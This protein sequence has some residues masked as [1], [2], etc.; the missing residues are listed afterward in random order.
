MAGKKLPSAHKSSKSN[1]VRVCSIPASAPTIEVQVACQGKKFDV[2]ALPDSGADGNL[3]S[4]N[5]LAQFGIFEFSRSTKRILAASDSEMRCFGTD[6]MHITFFERTVSLTAFVTPDIRGSLLSWKTS[7]AIGLLSDEYPT[8]FY[9]SNQ[10]T[11]RAVEFRGRTLS[12]SNVPICLNFRQLDLFAM[13]YHSDPNGHVDKAHSEMN[14][15]RYIWYYP[16]NGLNGL[17]GANVEIGLIQSPSEEVEEAQPCGETIVDH[18]EKHVDKVVLENAQVL[19]PEQ[20]EIA[21]RITI[22][23]IQDS[24]LLKLSNVTRELPQQII[25]QY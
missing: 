4:S 22:D 7:Q 3:I 13:D 17:T 15:V 19:P 11:M 18:E 14:E 16:L 25:G 2:M 23:N 1:A 24:E 8:P 9:M 20:I 12:M 5:V 10:Q 21:E 6:T